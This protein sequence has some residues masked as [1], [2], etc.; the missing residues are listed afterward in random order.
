MK[1]SNRYARLEKPLCF[2]AENLLGDSPTSPLT[3]A[4]KLRCEP[5]MI[6]TR[7][8]DLKYGLRRG[9]ETSLL[10]HMSVPRWKRFT[11]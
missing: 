11:S 1:H 2:Q 10:L 3:S 8:S 4:P 6:F 7:G 9:V 5:L